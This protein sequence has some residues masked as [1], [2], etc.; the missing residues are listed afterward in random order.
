MVRGNNEFF[1]QKRAGTQKNK[2]IMAAMS[3][4]LISRRDGSLES[5]DHLLTEYGIGKRQMVRKSAYFVHCT[6]GS[7]DQP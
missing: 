4:A 5:S 7:K 6:N 3:F 1:Q 2:K